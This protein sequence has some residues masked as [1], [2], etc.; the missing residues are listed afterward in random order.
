MS[1]LCCYAFVPLVFKNV[2]VFKGSITS[3]C[4]DGPL[5][6]YAVPAM[7]IESVLNKVVCSF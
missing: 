7:G 5:L 2:F 1:F 4:K 3:H 6:V